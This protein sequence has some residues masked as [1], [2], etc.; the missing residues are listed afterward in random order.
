MTDYIELWGLCS[1]CLRLFLQVENLKR[2]THSLKASGW[3]I[4]RIL[5][6]PNSPCCVFRDPN[7]VELAIYENT[8][9]EVDRKFA[10]QIDS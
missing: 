5:E 10:G 8:R 7:Q 1:P 9:P 6:I 3:E 2:V 4:D